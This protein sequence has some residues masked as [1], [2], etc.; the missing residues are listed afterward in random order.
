MYFL[1]LGILFGLLDGI[2]DR[3]VCKVGFEFCCVRSYDVKIKYCG[4][5]YVYCLVVLDLCL[6]RYCF[7]KIL[8]CLNVI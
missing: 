8:F 4:L 5:F 6:E 7:G 2:V 1:F 3:K